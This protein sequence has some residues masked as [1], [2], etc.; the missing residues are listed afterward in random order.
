MASR[1]P[2]ECLRKIF[3]DIVTTDINLD[4]FSRKDGVVYSN[5]NHLYSCILVNRTWCATAMPLLWKD[6]LHWLSVRYDEVV[7]Q[8]PTPW[9]ERFQFFIPF[10]FTRSDRLPMLI[11]TYFKCLPEKSRRSLKANK[12]FKGSE[13]IMDIK[14]YFDYPFFLERLNLPILANAVSMWN[15][16]YQ[17]ADE[18]FDEDTDTDEEVLPVSVLAEKLLRMFMERSGNLKYLSHMKSNI[19]IQCAVEIKSNLAVFP[20]AKLTLSKITSFHFNATSIKKPDKYYQALARICHSIENLEIHFLCSDS[21]GLAA[22]IESQRRL[23]RLLIHGGSGTSYFGNESG[24]IEYQHV[25]KALENKVSDLTYLNYQCNGGIPLGTF[26]SCKKL[27]RLLLHT[28]YYLCSDSFVKSEFPHLKSLFIEDGSFLIN[29]QIRIIQNSGGSITE[30]VNCMSEPRD[31]DNLTSFYETVMGFCPNIINFEYY[32]SK[33]QF[34]LIPNLFKKCNK[35]QK[36]I[37][38]ST[39]LPSDTAEINDILKRMGEVIPEKLQ[40]IEI[41]WHFTFSA[42]SLKSFLRGC[43]KRLKEPLRFKACIP[44]EEHRDILELYVNLG[45]LKENSPTF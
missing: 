8:L 39:S 29:H 32:I 9:K 31:P 28:L 2:V 27:E 36:V 35:L 12:A 30:I 7:N 40:K 25:V 22:L 5:L 1:M 11:S 37:F 19:S 23:L 6:P 17:S 21:K 43:H 18:L 45:V 44:T 4:P 33:N 13:F 10:T 20:G 14:P 34:S 16:Q 38:H 24:N 26:A 42:A 3:E 41:P 15:S